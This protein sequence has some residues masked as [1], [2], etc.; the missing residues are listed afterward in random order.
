V[1]QL[2]NAV[3]AG[4]QRADRMLSSAVHRPPMGG[5]WPHAKIG[6]S[7]GA[8]TRIDIDGGTSVIGSNCSGKR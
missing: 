2:L 3:L 4:D 6:P 8:L 7:E 1:G 5:R